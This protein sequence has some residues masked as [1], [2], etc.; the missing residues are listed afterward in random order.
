[1]AKFRSRGVE[2][3]HERPTLEGLLIHFRAYGL[4]EKLGYR[5]AK[6]RYGTY[7]ALAA[8]PLVEVGFDYLGVE[9]YVQLVEAVGYGEFAADARKDWTTEHS[10]EA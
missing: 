4:S 7:K 3:H 8:D 2:A 10:K 6:V 1:M 5:K 9:S